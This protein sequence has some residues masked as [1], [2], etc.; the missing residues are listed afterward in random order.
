MDEN[1]YQM[2]QSIRDEI[3][4]AS[5]LPRTPF[6][7]KLFWRLF[8]NITDR[9]AGLLGYFDHLVL[10]KGLPTASDWLLS[11]FCTSIVGH[12]LECIPHQGPLLVVSNHPGTYDGLILFS[13]LNR[14][15]IRWVGHE[16]PIYHLLPNTEKRVIFAPQKDHSVHFLTMRNAVDH[17]RHDGSLIYMGSGGRDPD[18]AIY[19]GAETYIDHWLG[20]FDVFLKSVPGLQIVP[21]VVSNVISL[22]W[23]HH[24]ITWLRQRKGWKMVI[25]EFGQ[26]ISQLV[27]PGQLML[28]PSISFGSPITAEQITNQDVRLTLIDEEKALLKE[29]MQLCCCD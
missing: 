23:A 25:S 20:S 4:I 2:S 21:A 13:A 22:K 19:P 15:D 28:T 17:L 12:G 27:H 18:P 10:E 3:L 6:T 7:R 29:H 16:F 8:S 1:L 26:I 9:L 5:G 24:P 14:P 11:N